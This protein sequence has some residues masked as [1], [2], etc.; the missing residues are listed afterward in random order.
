MKTKIVIGI[1]AVICVGLVIGLV[2]TKNQGDEQQ[3][4]DGAAINDF[5]NQL[6]TARTSL[7]D[8]SQVN[9]KLT[10][11][12]AATEQEVLQLSNSLTE[13]SAALAGTKTSLDRK[14]VV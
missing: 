8:L 1:L 6:A 11:D 9:L 12:L 7:D 13:T 3:K 2:V 4:N 10:N 14:S 5:S